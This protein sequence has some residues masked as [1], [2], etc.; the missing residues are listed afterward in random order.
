MNQST[1][2][3]FD[4]QLSVFYFSRH[5]I[6]EM[7]MF[8]HESEYTG[9]TDNNRLY[10]SV[11]CFMHLLSFLPTFFKPSLFI[12][13]E[14]QQQLGTSRHI[15]S[16]LVFRFQC[17]V[18]VELDQPAS[19]QRWTY[20]WLFRTVSMTVSRRHWNLSSSSS[21]LSEAFQEMKLVCGMMLSTLWSAGFADAS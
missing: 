15:W 5:F 3:W 17:S 19:A 21:R 12:A 2:T 8:W 4:F 6:A 18:P 11:K 20:L 14:K 16:S 10:L 9:Y 1:I 13:T 7:G